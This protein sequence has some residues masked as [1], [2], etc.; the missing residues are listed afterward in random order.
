MN[1]QNQQNNETDGKV[2]ACRDK[3]LACM[4]A[5]DQL[6]V[7]IQSQTQGVC[8]GQLKLNPEYLDACNRLCH[9]T[10]QRVS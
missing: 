2:C 9:T 10:A 8:L 6:K 4:H 5:P 1:E 7:L 3:G